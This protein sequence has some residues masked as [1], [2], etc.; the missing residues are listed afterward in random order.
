M[1]AL[2]LPSRL[3]PSKLT[4]FKDCPKAFQFANI[5]RLPEASSRHLVLGTFVHLALELT[6]REMRGLRKENALTCLYAAW[7]EIF[8]DPDYRALELDANGVYQFCADAEKLFRNALLLEDP[9]EVSV[10]STEQTLEVEVAGVRY[11]GIIDRIDSLPGGGYGVVD[12]KTGRVPSQT[13]EREK[14]LGVHFY[15]LLCQQVFGK[16]PEWIRLDYLADPVSVTCI[17][18]Q[19]SVR[20]LRNQAGAVWA[21]IEAAC[22]NDDFQPRQSRLCS[23]CSYQAICPLFGGTR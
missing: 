17:P 7:I 12:Y 10:H 11:R 14:M 18:T 4:A 15:A 23:W 9:D 22:A 8:H 13:S 5:D 16:L 1:T 2:T 19:Q 3:S 21:A 6:Y 20:G